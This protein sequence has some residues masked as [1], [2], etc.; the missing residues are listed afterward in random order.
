MS[1]FGFKGMQSVSNRSFAHRAC[2]LNLETNVYSDFHLGTNLSFTN[3][4][5]QALL[6]CSLGLHMGRAVLR[7]KQKQLGTDLFW[8]SG[9]GDEKEN[10][11]SWF[12]V[13]GETQRSLGSVCSHSRDD[14]SR[15]LCFSVQESDIVNRTVW[16]QC[17]HKPNMNTCWHFPRL[18][19]VQLFDRT[20]QWISG[21]MRESVDI[22]QTRSEDVGFYCVL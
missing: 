5:P 3:A 4:S 18:Q 7:D 2:I 17:V 13:T 8:K 15:A 14:R 16:N 6:I 9:H 1:Y 22:S 11:Q 12:P 21:N 20:R 19:P 10:P